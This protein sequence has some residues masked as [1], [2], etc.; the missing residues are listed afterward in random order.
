MSAYT[1]TAHDRDGRYRL[2]VSS[3]FGDHYTY[4]EHDDNPLS[5][6]RAAVAELFDV[7]QGNLRMVKLR[8]P[9]GGVWCV[10]ATVEDG[11]AL[12]DWGASND[13]Q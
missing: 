5:A 1:V 2:T 10:R 13:G 8:D 7:E 9:N 4:A 12:N 6:A 3:R 11:A